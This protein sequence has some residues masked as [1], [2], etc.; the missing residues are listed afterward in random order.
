MDPA[1]VDTQKS[2]HNCEKDDQQCTQ[3]K[4]QT[5]FNV[6]LFVEMIKIKIYISKA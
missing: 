4:I 2:F 3:N 6:L 5:N 1:F